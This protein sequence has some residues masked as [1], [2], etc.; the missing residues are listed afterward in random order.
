MTDEPGIRTNEGDGGPK[1]RMLCLVAG[2]GRYFARGFVDVP[3]AYANIAEV[4]VALRDP[5]ILPEYEKVV[6]P[7][8][9]AGAVD[10]SV[11]AI[12]AI[13]SDKWDG[14][15]FY[16]VGH[17]HVYREEIFLACWDTTAEGVRRVATSASFDDIREAIQVHPVRDVIFIA[18]ACYS[19]RLFDRHIPGKRALTWASSAT[20]EPTETGHGELTTFTSLVLKVLRGAATPQRAMSLGEATTQLYRRYPSLV[21]T[22]S[23]LIGSVR[24]WGPDE[25]WSGYGRG[26]SDETSSRDDE[27]TSQP[28][29]DPINETD[30]TNPSIAVGLSDIGPLVAG[31]RVPISFGRWLRN[32]SLWARLLFGAALLLL[33]TGAVWVETSPDSPSTLSALVNMFCSAA[34]IAVFLLRAPR[35]ARGGDARQMDAAVLRFRASWIL[36]WVTWLMFYAAAVIFPG[37]LEP[38]TGGAGMID[39]SNSLQGVGFYFVFRELSEKTRGI[40][41]GG[42]ATSVTAVVALHIS[43]TLIAQHEQF[44]RGSVEVNIMQSFAG[45]L[46]GTAIALFVGRIESVFVKPPNVLRHTWFIYAVLQPLYF[47]FDDSFDSHGAVFYAKT[48]L[49]LFAAF[50]KGTMA[51]FVYWCYRHGRLLYYL[52]NIRDAVVGV[53]VDYYNFAA[54][55]IA[56]AP[57]WV[58][59]KSLKR[60][61]ER[62]ET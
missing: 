15:L 22:Q 12:E 51:V 30:D 56:P 8:V 10:F 2:T 23:G 14:V 46:V 3:Q 21:T 42:M 16:Y 62:G 19:E 47:L 7:I 13:E 17:A 11:R 28:A 44:S 29:M 61:D 35:K 37:S 6:M 5:R 57:G 52:S 60:D 18:D 26:T 9:D 24:A 20:R 32:L 38:Y 1:P 33:V 43:F 39:A 31:G 4:Q 36:L 41:W 58:G 45:G 27:S 55:Q 59:W 54:T 53:D 50:A 48:S 40:P 49:I 34:V 25:S